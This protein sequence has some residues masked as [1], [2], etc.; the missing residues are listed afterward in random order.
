MNVRCFRLTDA[1]GHGVEILGDAL[2]ISAQP[3]AP[4]Q[5]MSVRHP[6]ELAGSTRTVL[7]I[8]AFRRGVGGDDSWGAPVLPQYTYAADKPYELKFIIRSI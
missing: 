1:D 6:D 2:Q 4:E 7:N 8:A 5:L 3:Y